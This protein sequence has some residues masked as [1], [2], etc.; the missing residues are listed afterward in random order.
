METWFSWVAAHGCLQTEARTGT[1][2]EREGTQHVHQ[3]KLNPNKLLGVTLWW[4]S[5]R[6]E[7]GVCSHLVCGLLRLPAEFTA[8]C[9]P[10]FSKN[11]S[12]AMIRPSWLVHS[13]KAVKEICRTENFASPW[14]LI[15]QKAII[16][17]LWPNGGS[18]DIIRP[19][20]AKWWWGICV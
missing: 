10:G 18:P 19:W 5:M 20:F 1:L 17:K 14:L 16:G 7:P 4:T 6:A 3:L 15:L 11:Y 13:R 9:S 12:P 2:S 8:V